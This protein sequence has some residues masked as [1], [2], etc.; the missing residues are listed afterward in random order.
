MKD[1]GCL[2]SGRQPTIGALGSPHPGAPPSSMVFA[3]SVISI[4]AILLAPFLL[5]RFRNGYGIVIPR[6]FP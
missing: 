6:T 5:I 3:A 1:N 2:G 4:L